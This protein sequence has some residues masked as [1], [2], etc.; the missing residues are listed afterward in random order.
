[1]V[2]RITKKD[3]DE[4]ERYLI[5]MDGV[6]D[7]FLDE[8]RAAGYELDYSLDSL[9]ALERY[10]LAISPSAKD[11]ELLANRMARYYGEASA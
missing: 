5:E 7:R 6:L 2:R 8:A 9:D 1:M 11:P 10:W 4:F 3:R